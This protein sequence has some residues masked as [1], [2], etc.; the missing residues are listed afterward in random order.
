MYSHGIATM[1][2]AEAYGRGDKSLKS[3]LEE[4][5]NLIVRSQNTEHKPDILGGSIEKDSPSYG[6]WRYYPNDTDSD[7]SVSGWQVVPLKALE[8]GGFAVPK[9]SWKA[10]IRFMKECYLKEEGGFVYMP[11]ESKTGCARS[12]MGVLS[13]QLA[14]QPDCPEVKGGLEYIWRYPPLWET[15]QK[16]EGYP[17]YYWYYATR[18]MYR[19]GGD[20]WE[21]WSSLTAQMLL[22]YQNS[23]GSWPIAE[24]EK[25]VG[26]A[27]STALATLILE[28]CQGHLPLYL[29]KKK[30]LAELG[31][32]TFYAT[33][34]DSA[35]R[36]ITDLKNADFHI[37][38]DGQAVEKFT[39]TTEL[40]PSSIVLV[41]DRSGSMKKAMEETKKA[42]Q[43]FIKLLAPNDE[44][45]VIAFDHEIEIAQNFTRDKESLKTTLGAIKA[46]GGTA[47]Y[48]TILEAI[49]KAGRG[50]GRP[51]IIL[52]TDGADENIKGTGPGSKH[53]LEETLTRIKQKNIPIYTLGL[54]TNVNKEVLPRISSS[55]G[56]RFYFSF[57][58]KE[59]K[60]IYEE[61]AT[62]LKNQYKITFTSPNPVADGSW[63]NVFIKIDLK[64]HTKEGYYG[65]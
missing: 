7:I 40:L 63:R 49:Q 11:E 19:A 29:Q 35:G 45:M 43:S 1:A 13:L 21:N 15:E 37:E 53:T 54:G 50:K 22:K 32:I 26:P 10:I 42:A 30:T 34:T 27:Y 33:V 6:G 56:G 9:W 5:L 3:I 65:Q 39:V 60:K 36:Y 24:S 17:F 2:L 12:G 14:G 48:D 44:A 20:D 8:A 62:E 28:M 59:L 46:Q 4:A 51:A 31:P 58:T 16:G 38:E 57:S 52:L 55:S 23:D 18:A 47:L 25:L 64:I 61:I 41:L